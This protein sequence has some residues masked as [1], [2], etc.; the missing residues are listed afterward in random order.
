MIYVQNCIAC[1]NTDPSKPGSVGPE[2]ANSSRELL[3]MRIIEGKYPAGYTP[4]RKTSQM[5]PLPHL[6]PEIPALEAYLSKK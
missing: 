4:K 1:H 3:E 6:K 5:P 2:I